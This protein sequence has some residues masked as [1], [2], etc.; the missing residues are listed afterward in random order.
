MTFTVEAKKWPWT[1][2]LTKNGNTMMKNYLTTKTGL[3]LSGILILGSFGACSLYEKAPDTEPAIPQEKQWA[4]KYE[5]L[6]KESR[7][8]SDRLRAELATLKIA[9]AKNKGTLE[10]RGNSTQEEQAF[11]S[12]VDSLKADIVKLKGERDQLRNQNSQLQARSE[13]LPGMRQ[14]VMDIKA[15]QTSVHQLVTKMETLSADIIQVKQDIVLQ[16]QT[17]QTVPPKLS[18]LPEIEPN[19]RKTLPPRSAPPI[20]RPTSRPT[21][22]T[23]ITVEY[24]D[25]LWDIARAHDISVEELKEMNG[26]V[27]DS[28]YVDQQL[29]VPLTQSQPSKTD[30]QPALAA[31]QGKNQ[32]T[33]MTDDERAPNAEEGP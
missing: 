27:T 13:A 18:K 12:E 9:A 6:V 31:T 3:F 22:L 5:I 1:E 15:L 24:G 2:L 30:S 17:L 8:E 16:E 11:T 19:P 32:S 29:N 14:L 4:G 7:A 26:L 33:D 23:T 10:P 25:T 28:I 21:G 20:S